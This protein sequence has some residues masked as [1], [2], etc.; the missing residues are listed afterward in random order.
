MRERGEN[1]VFLRSKHLEVH[2]CVTSPPAADPT[3]GG[4]AH[5]GSGSASSSSSA[6]AMGAGA[7]AGGVPLPPAATREEGFFGPT[8]A[9]SASGAASSGSLLGGR[10]SYS[11]LGGGHGLGSDGLLLGSGAMRAPFTTLQLYCAL[12]NPTPHTQQLSDVHVHRGAPQFAELFASLSHRASGQSDVGVIYTAGPANQ[13]LTPVSAS[14]LAAAGIPA[15]SAKQLQAYQRTV[16][17]LKDQCTHHQR[18]SGKIYRMHTD[19]DV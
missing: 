9:Q 3:G 7:G 12:K 4:G 1:D 5:A 16:A 19:L 8:L 2:V 14:Y 11:G 13:R 10:A 18:Q 15:P 17:Q 6:S